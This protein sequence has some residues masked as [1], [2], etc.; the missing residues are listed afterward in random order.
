MYPRI[1][2]NEHPSFWTNGYISQSNSAFDGEY[3]RKEYFLR[4]LPTTM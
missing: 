1:R 3:Y 4:K 2:H